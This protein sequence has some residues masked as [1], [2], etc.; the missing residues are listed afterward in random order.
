ML[1]PH[2]PILSECRPLAN[3]AGLCNDLTFGPAPAQAALRM[4]VPISAR[5]P[6]HSRSGCIENTCPSSMSARH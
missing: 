6:G 4:Y 1:R 5:A 3:S 2:C